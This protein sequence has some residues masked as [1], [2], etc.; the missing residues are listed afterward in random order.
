[1]WSLRL[2]YRQI[3]FLS[4]TRSLFIS[5]W[6]QLTHEV[7]FLL[8]IV[9]LHIILWR[10]K[11]CW[12]KP[13]NYCTLPAREIENG[14]AWICFWSCL[15]LM[16]YRSF[17]RIANCWRSLNLGFCAICWCSNSPSST[18][19]KYCI[20]C[21]Q[22]GLTRWQWTRIINSKYNT[23][24]K[25]AVNQRKST[26]TSAT[27]RRKHFSNNLRGLT[28]IIFKVSR[29]LS[30]QQHKTRS[31]SCNNI[32]QARQ[33]GGSMR[34]VGLDRVKIITKCCLFLLLKLSQI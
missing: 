29:L 17:I 14:A 20:N 7:I 3:D 10:N 18:F 16:I 13:V 15:S 27:R 5:Q 32:L 19:T 22:C 26:R 23:V 6:V 33:T 34:F 2:I 8:F 12:H 24:R 28:H 4:L 25:N 21:M 9:W 31:E 30:F 11:F 1:M